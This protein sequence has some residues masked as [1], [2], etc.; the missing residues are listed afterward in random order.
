M[1]VSWAKLHKYNYAFVNKLRKVKKIM[2]ISLQ[3][4]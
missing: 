1:Y 2:V 3:N 4:E